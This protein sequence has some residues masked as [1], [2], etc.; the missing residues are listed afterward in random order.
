MHWKGHKMKIHFLHPTGLAAEQA[1]HLGAF[2]SPLVGLTGCCGF[3]SLSSIV[4]SPEKG[5][6]SASETNGVSAA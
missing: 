1:V 6:E 2:E 3:M 5:Q 4:A